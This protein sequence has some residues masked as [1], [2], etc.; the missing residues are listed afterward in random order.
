MLLKNLA[1]Y[2]ALGASCALAATNIAEAI[3]D[4]D[5]LARAIGDA[6]DSLQ[7][8]QGGV[9]GALD[10]AGAVNNAKLAARTARE[11]L[12]G[13]G[14][15]TPDEAAQYYEAYTKMS[16]VLLDALTVA[17]DKAPLYNEA[18]VGLQARESVQDLHSEKKMFEE[19]ANQQIP[20]ETMGKAAPS[21]EQ[22]SKAFEEA[23]AAFL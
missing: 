14:G 20:Q 22:I 19:Q 5:N 7:N 8:Y 15:F 17:K 21:I 2:L 1:G 16:P 11:N 10:T 13:S 3:S 4:M 9:S 12:A 6:R 23:E 18:G